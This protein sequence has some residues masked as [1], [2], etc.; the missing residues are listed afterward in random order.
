MSIKDC[1]TEIIGFEFEEEQWEQLL[2]D[3]YNDETINNP[4]YD[5]I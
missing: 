5:W 3:Y 4:N 1:A 2:G